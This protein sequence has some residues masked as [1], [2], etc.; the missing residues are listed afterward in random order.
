M[1]GTI[2]RLLLLAAVAARF[3]TASPTPAFVTL[4]VPPE[5]DAALTDAESASIA[6]VDS[7]GH[8][9]YVVKATD[10]AETVTATVVAGPN[11]FSIAPNGQDPVG[12]ECQ[13]QATDGTCTLF[14]S[15]QTAVV[16]ESSLGKVVLDVPAT[17]A[18]SAEA[19]QTGKPNSSQRTSY[20]LS[21]PFVIMG[22][23]L[24]YLL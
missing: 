8:T 10:A 14:N 17:G 19:A 11:Y 24:A 21:A 15:A 5:Y 16:T 2:S 3:A 20:S 4:I 6:G 13:L 12:L 23:S 18:G 22:V 7:Q 9:T 1:A